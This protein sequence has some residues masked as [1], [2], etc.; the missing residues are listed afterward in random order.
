[1]DPYQ[2]QQT[3]QPTPNPEPQPPIPPQQFAPAEQPVAVQPEHTFTPPPT[4]PLQPPQ[5]M[6]PMQ[7]PIQ[8]AQPMQPT[9]FNPQQYQPIQQVPG[10]PYAQSPMQSG[11]N[12]SHKKLILAGAGGFVILIA[13]VIGFLALG[14]DDKGSDNANSSDESSDTSRAD[15]LGGETEQT[16]TS[17]SKP[18]S[19]NKGFTVSAA[20]G[21]LIYD[22]RALTYELGV[23]G[24]SDGF[25]LK[26]FDEANQYVMLKF[27]VKNR[28]DRAN[29]IYN[30]AISLVDESGEEYGQSFAYYK[31]SEDDW[32]GRA[33]YDIDNIPVN[34]T[35]TG[36]LMFEV[37]KDAKSLTLAFNW[38][39]NVIGGTDV[40]EVK[41]IK[42][43]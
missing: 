10:N 23:V 19:V 42:L 1:L 17:S 28:G 6:Q 16:P 21:Q 33:Y 34:K 5:P 7:Q 31:S 8:P 37:P 14:G 35:K 24:D 20:S 11:A 13:L 3:P 43:F 22:F 40:S 25:E 39:V 27:S 18:V 9:T 36:H 26:P 15:D 30:S 38:E 4:Q 2:N 41:K 29:N 12:A 32:G